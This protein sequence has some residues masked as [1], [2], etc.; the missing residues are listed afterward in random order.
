MNDTTGNRANKQAPN[1]VHRRSSA[2]SYCKPGSIYSRSVPF[3]DAAVMLASRE[4]DN[5]DIVWNNSNMGWLNCGQP[6]E[7]CL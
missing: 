7:D 4:T 5:N 3:I 6:T 1:H 2:E